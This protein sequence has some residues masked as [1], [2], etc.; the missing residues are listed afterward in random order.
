M[1]RPVSPRG[2]LCCRGEEELNPERDYSV[3]LV[4]ESCGLTVVGRWPRRSSM[5]LDEVV[6]LE[7][8]GQS[9]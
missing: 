5:G 2:E 1:S 4:A 7:Q 3:L 8:Q 6:L 9:V